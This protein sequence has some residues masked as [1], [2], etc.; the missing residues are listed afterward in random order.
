MASHPCPGPSLG[1]EAGSPQP[2]RS[3]CSLCG[4][5]SAA[6]STATRAAGLQLARAPGTRGH[7]PLP[8]APGSPELSGAW[9][10]QGGSRQGPGVSLGR[11]RPPATLRPGPSGRTLASAASPFCFP[12][13]IRPPPLPPW[14]PRPGLTSLPDLEPGWGHAYLVS[15]ADAV[16]VGP[17]QVAAQQHLLQVVAVA[18]EDLG[19]Q[20]GAHGLH[21]AWPADTGG[22]CG[23]PRAPAGL[24]AHPPCRGSHLSSQLTH[25]THAGHGK[26]TAAWGRAEMPRPLPRESLQWPGGVT[27]P[28]VSVKGG[29]GRKLDSTRA[30]LQDGCVLFLK[31]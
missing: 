19:L 5:R 30:H 23:H 28:A 9:D 1:A 21:P 13:G 15:R 25:R 3:P 14:R 31:A 24:P 22:A 6:P 7:L 11:P 17:H 29:L 18:A 8:G 27:I 16:L 26:A 4:T 2:A 10:R 20:P 12:P